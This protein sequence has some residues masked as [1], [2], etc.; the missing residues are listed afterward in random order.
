MSIHSAVL[1]LLRHLVLL[2]VGYTAFSE[3]RNT[4]VT[5]S[6]AYTAFMSQLRARLLPV[7]RVVVLGTILRGMFFH[8]RRAGC[9]LWWGGL[10]VLMCRRRGRSGGLFILGIGC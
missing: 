8:G 1:D 5:R 2:G 3:W 4:A 9:G 7:A 10:C 6:W